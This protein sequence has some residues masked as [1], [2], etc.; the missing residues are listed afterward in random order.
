MTRNLGLAA[1]AIVLLVAI[2]WGLSAIGWT[3]YRF[4]A[5]KYEEARREVFVETPSY[6]L[7]KRQFLSR[8]HHDWKTT[9]DSSHRAAICASARHEAATIDPE[10]LTPDLRAWECVR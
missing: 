7:G 5:P 2:L 4:W 1:L 8:L 10:H 6:V 3:H 9:D